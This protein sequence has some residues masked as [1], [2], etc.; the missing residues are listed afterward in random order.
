MLAL[1]R[2]ESHADQLDSEQQ[3][4]QSYYERVRKLMIRGTHRGGRSIRK[5]QIGGDA[6]KLL[7]PVNDRPSV[8]VEGKEKKHKTRKRKNQERSEDESRDKHRHRLLHDFHARFSFRS[9][10]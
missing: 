10:G 6:L 4:E 7:D 2:H 3:A 5:R 9:G 8:D 1:K